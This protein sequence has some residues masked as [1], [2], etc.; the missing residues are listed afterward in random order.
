MSAAAEGISIVCVSGLS[1]TLLLD[2]RH[3]SWRFCLFYSFLLLHFKFVF[4]LCCKCYI[5]MWILFVM[6]RNMENLQ[7]IGHLGILGSR[8]FA[9]NSSRDK[10]QISGTPCIF[11][12]HWYYAGY[13]Y[14]NYCVWKGTCRATNAAT[15]SSKCC[16]RNFIGGDTYRFITSKYLD[17]IN[18][19]EFV[20]SCNCNKLNAIFWQPDL[21]SF[22]F[23]FVVALYPPTL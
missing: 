8:S 7:C 21:M 2:T 3:S 13:Y 6:L 16:N 19:V 18:V 11:W 14:G 4:L 12:H 9:G 20:W 1:L 22:Q 10:A 15:W 17:V 5:R 23:M